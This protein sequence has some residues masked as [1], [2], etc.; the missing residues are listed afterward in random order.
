M[1]RGR[2]ALLWLLSSTTLAAL[3]AFAVLRWHQHH[4][5][6]PSPDPLSASEERFHS[7]LHQNLNL[8][9]AEDAALHAAESSFASRRKDLRA[10]MSA[11]ES[12]LRRLILRDG[13]DSPELKAAVQRLASAQAELQQAVLTHLF[14]M[15]DH[16]DPVQRQQLIQWT[17]D[18][19]RQVP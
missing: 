5:H 17:H 2:L 19:L 4:A 16:L 1:N 10:A 11:A 3:T 15:A 14:T 18:S 7:W 13:K 9:P 12:D 6:Q 8:S